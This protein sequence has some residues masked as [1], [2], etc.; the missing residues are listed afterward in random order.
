MFS[1]YCHVPYW[2]SVCCYVSIKN[3]IIMRTLNDTIRKLIPWTGLSQAKVAESVGI[4][5][6]Q[7]SQYLNGNA[8]ANKDVLEKLMKLVGLDHSIAAN[9]IDLVSRAAKKL[10]AD[11]VSQE[12]V[13]RYSQQQMVSKTG[14]KEFTVFKDVTRRELEYIIKSHVSDYADTYP[15]VKALVVLTMGMDKSNSKSFTKSFYDTV[16]NLVP[17]KSD[18]SVAKTIGNILA[19]GAAGLA[20]GPV[21]ATTALLGGTIA[22]TVGKMAQDKYKS[23]AGSM[24]ASVVE[25]A[26]QLARK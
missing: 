19:F 23:L 18:D 25:L 1:L 15:Y 9:R 8:S 20:L 10:R 24:N 11:G 2:L 17:Q 7:L 6:A 12:A 5:T 22:A 4:S 13:S 21:V 16:K 3:I 14:M 26:L